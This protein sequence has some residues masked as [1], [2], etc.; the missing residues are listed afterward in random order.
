MTENNSQTQRNLGKSINTWVQTVGILI[1]AGWGVY[2][3]VYKEIMVPKSAPVNITLNLQLKKIGTG[4]TK[5]NLTAVE[6]KCSAT[7]P[8]SRQI[9]LL[10]SAWIAY[11]VRITATNVEEAN[12]SEAAATALRD[13]EGLTPVNR[14]ATFENASVVALGRLFPDTVLKPGETSGRTIV[15]YIHKN[16][17]DLVDLTVTMPSAAD[18]RGIELEW[19]LTE[20]SVLTPAIYRL[21]KNAPRTP[22]PEAEYS[23]KPFE[24]QEAQA[25]AEISLWPE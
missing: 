12:F 18:P 24:L 21:N 10:P 2:T 22:M 3:F 6:V 7:N 19:T 9:H 23:A 20:K 16:D 11:G 17:Y 5:G 25:S 15:F 13:S 8:S 14:Q 4:V 1:A